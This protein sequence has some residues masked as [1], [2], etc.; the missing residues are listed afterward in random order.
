MEKNVL[1]YFVDTNSSRGFVSFGESNFGKLE[2]VVKLDGY[3]DL[4]VTQLVSQACAQALGCEQEVELIHNGLDNSLQGIILPGRKAGLL[5]IP[6]Y[7]D[8]SYSLRLTEDGNLSKARELLQKA[9][10]CFGQALKI[11]DDWEKIFISNMDFETMDELGEETAEKLFGGKKAEGAGSCVDRF[12]GAATVN[13][14][15]DYIP[16]ITQEIPK[17]YFLKGRP[18]TGKSTF[19][20][21]LAKAARDRGYRV[22]IYHCAFDPNSL[23]MIAVRELG[24]C[25]FDSTAPHEY[26]PDRDS[27]EIIDIYK[28]AV[29]PG[30]DEKYEKEIAGY[31]AGYKSKVREATGYLGEAKLAYHQYQKGVLESVNPDRR[32]GA[33][34]WVMAKLFGR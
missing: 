29:Q 15:Y 16:N 17:R 25:V 8:A 21:K 28:A 1:H 31:S 13:G 5:N 11:H 34:D 33:M 2:T 7:T 12:F 24:L 6:A 26:F 4:L 32:I 22:E 9:Y 19:L 3:P 10:D 23:D 20:K 18:G 14:S 27:D 30:T